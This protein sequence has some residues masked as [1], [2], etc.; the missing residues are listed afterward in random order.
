[1]KIGY[2]GHEANFLMTLAAVALGARIV[3]RHF[4]LDNSM[5][6]SDHA[7]SLDPSAFTE[8][9]KAVRTLE[10]GLGSPLK[11]LQVGAHFAT[12]TD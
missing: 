7:S 8:M 1:M 2:S 5:K 11:Q 6:G 12:A 10:L 3:E 4:T 9:V